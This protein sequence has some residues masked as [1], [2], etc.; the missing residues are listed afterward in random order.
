MACNVQD[1]RQHLRRRSGT[2]ANLDVGAVATLHAL[3]VFL[4]H[5]GSKVW[6][7]SVSLR[8]APPPGIPEYIDVW[9]KS[10]EAPADKGTQVLPAML[11]PP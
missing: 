1:V 2:P 6:V 7:F 5:L 4:C 11:M 9:S 8:A 3:N 10:I